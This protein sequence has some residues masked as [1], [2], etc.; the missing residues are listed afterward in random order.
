MRTDI[1]P[2]C[3]IHP[4]VVMVRVEL[5]LKVDIDEFAKP[6]Y[7]CP[8]SGC[9]YHYDIV[10]GYFT[11]RVGGGLSRDMAFWQRCSNDGLP[12]FVAGF[13]PQKSKRNWKC[14]Q[15]TCDGSR[16]TEGELHTAS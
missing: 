2:L 12:M 9:L 8:E 4:A 5:W 13:E 11:T 10:S 6:A 16:I 14:A 1:R 3:P 7:A 15:L